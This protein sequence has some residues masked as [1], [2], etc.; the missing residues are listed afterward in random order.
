VRDLIVTRA[1]ETE[2]SALTE[3]LWQ[4][5]ESIPAEKH[6]LELGEQGKIMRKG[7]KFVRR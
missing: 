4:L 1:D 6:N 7:L 2:R 5:S 3:N